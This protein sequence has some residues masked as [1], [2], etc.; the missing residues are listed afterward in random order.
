M[1]G[2]TIR[3][4]YAA[5][6][7]KI[8]CE[9]V[10]DYRYRLLRGVVERLRAGGAAPPAMPVA[11]R[12]RAPARGP[13]LGARVRA[14]P[15]AKW[16]NTQSAIVL[17]WCPSVHTAYQDTR[18]FILAVRSAG[19]VSYRALN[20]SHGTT[21]PTRNRILVIAC[22]APEKRKTNGGIWRSSLLGLLGLLFGLFTCPRLPNPLDL[23]PVEP[24]EV[25]CDQKDQNGYRRKHGK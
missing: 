3:H 18:G 20:G 10:L 1:Y 13:R 15:S 8:Q 16:P 19:R 22:T 7:E 25:G 4:A 9:G 21:D 11:A 6:T 23:V 2:T 24:R 12:G 14:Y 5:F 17:G